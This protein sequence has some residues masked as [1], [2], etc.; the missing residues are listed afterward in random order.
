MEN[1]EAAETMGKSHAHYLMHQEPQRDF[2]N[3]PRSAG[4]ASK[5]ISEIE[6]IRLKADN[7]N[8]KITA[9]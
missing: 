9:D 7:N 3:F 6:Q 1:D 5:A 8:N 2:I 4:E